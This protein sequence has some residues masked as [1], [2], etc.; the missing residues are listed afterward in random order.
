MS[1]THRSPGGCGWGGRAAIILGIGLAAVFIGFVAQG[2]LVVFTAAVF[3]V[4][5]DGATA[6]ACRYSRLPRVL[7]LL[8]TV[9]ILTAG[10]GAVLWLGAISVAAQA[11]ALQ[12]DLQQS[13]RQLQHLLR[14]AGLGTIGPTAAE[15]LLAGLLA[16][17]VTIQGTIAGTA[18]LA[19][20]LLVILVAGL[21][22]AIRPRG[23]VETLVKLFPI[24]RRNRVREVMD[25]MGNALRLWLA[26]RLAAMLLVGV[27]SGIGM[28]I[29]H[30]RLPVLLGFIAGTLTFIPYLGMVI[31]LIPAA[32]VALLTGPASALYVLMLY[33]GIHLLEGYVLTPMI[34]KET[35]DLAPAWLVV[36]QTFGF[37]LAGLFGAT[38]ATPAA[39]VATVAVQ[40]LYVQDFLGD[41]VRILGHRKPKA[42]P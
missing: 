30:V 36:A 5:L 31:A 42:M 4:G 9:V 1:A 18:N 23:Y 26:G 37:L 12:Q 33:L 13:V 39:I 34:Q 7:G 20:D 25:A 21:Y 16:R 6:F 17:V 24:R 38:M 41:R 27:G 22:F 28:A 2:V 14:Q 40:M 35:V 32:L 29:L 15:H 8:A 11:P 3:A 10:V 19:A